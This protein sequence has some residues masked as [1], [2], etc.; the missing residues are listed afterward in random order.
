MEQNEIERHHILYAVT[1]VITSYLVNTFLSG[2]KIEFFKF[3][4]LGFILYIP[5]LIF[6]V[7]AMLFIV[8]ALFLI[9]LPSDRHIAKKP[10]GLG[11]LYLTSSGIITTFLINDLAK[12]VDNN[13]ITIILIPVLFC[14]VYWVNKRMKIG[15]F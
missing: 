12:I 13:L 9:N 3:D 4:Y 7:K 6:S 11:E 1:T 8:L 14:G 10:I 5:L 2:I 15:H